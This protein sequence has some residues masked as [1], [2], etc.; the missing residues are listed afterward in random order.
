MFCN[1]HKTSKSIKM[2]QMFLMPS[3]V[4]VVV[5]YILLTLEYSK[6]LLIYL[7]NVYI[8]LIIIIVFGMFIKI[9]NVMECYYFIRSYLS[10]R[11]Y[12]LLS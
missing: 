9:Q 7:L 6:F 4:I 1:V 8:N 11:V 10:Y 5:E 2:Y 12:I 3:E